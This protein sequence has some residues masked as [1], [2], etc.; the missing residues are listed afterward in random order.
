MG[1]T[2]LTKRLQGIP[3]VSKPRLGNTSALETSA[4]G[5]FKGSHVVEER[6]PTPTIISHIDRP[7][8]GWV[9]F[10]NPTYMTVLFAVSRKKLRNKAGLSADNPAFFVLEMRSLKKPLKKCKKC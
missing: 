3:L 10:L 6:N 9:S 2:A 4:S 7:R 1:E 5:C 8:K